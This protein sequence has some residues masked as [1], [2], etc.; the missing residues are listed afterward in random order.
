M[1]RRNPLWVIFAGGFVAVLALAG[2]G[3]AEARRDPVVREAAIVLPDWPAGA[4]P[5]RLVLLSD[6]HIGTAAMGP[7]RLARIVEQINALSPDIVLIAGDFIFGHAP[8]SAA[9]LGEPMVAPLSRLR[10]RLGVVAALGNHDHWTG[11]DTVRAL[12][13]RAG[14]TVVDNS[15]IARGPLALGVAGDDFTGRADLAATIKAVRR[16]PGARLILTHSPDIAPALPSDIALLLAGHTHCGQVVL[17]LLGPI[18]EVSRYGARYRCG[19]RR[20]GGRTVVVT[21][22]LGTSGGPFRLG[23]PPDIWLLTLGAA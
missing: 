16:L 21:A 23:A 20:E 3:F 11:A 15:A 6:M 5:I 14:V 19:V 22:G 12:L 2:Y 1:I 7:D 8:G 4:P 18:S 17:P 10:A 13:R 9:R